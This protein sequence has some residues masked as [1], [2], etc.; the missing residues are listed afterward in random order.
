MWALAGFAGLFI[1][2]AVTFIAWKAYFDSY[3]ERAIEKIVQLKG[4]LE[5]C[6][7][8]I[9]E[10]RQEIIHIHEYAVPEQVKD[11]KFGG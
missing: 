9:I 11:I 4:Q 1:G 8:A 2:S 10:A 5:K 3:N 6:R 7:E